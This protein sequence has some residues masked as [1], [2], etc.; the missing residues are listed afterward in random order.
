MREFK[1]VL[2]LVD[3]R[4]K[5]VAHAHCMLARALVDTCGGYT[6]ID[7][8]GGWRDNGRDM[9]EAVRVYHVA[10]DNA[11]RDSAPL[12]AALIRA[13]FMAGQEAVYMVSP[14]S[15]ATIVKCSHAASLAA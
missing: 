1:L 13:G 9:H 5:C 8:V 4:G 7:G 10:S 12:L 15:G 11:A 14:D 2:P 6:A 3:N